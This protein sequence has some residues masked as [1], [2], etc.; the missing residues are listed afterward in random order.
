MHIQQLTQQDPV[1][2]T[3]HPTVYLSYHSDHKVP[4][5]QNIFTNL[6]NYRYIKHKILKVTLHSYPMLPDFQMSIACLKVQRVSPI[7]HV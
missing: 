5:S 1:Q 2:Y 7:C 4:F 6:Y 3:S